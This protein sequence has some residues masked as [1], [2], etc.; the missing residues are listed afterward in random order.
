[1]MSVE[2]YLEHAKKQREFVSG[3]RYSPYHWG[4]S[5]CDEILKNM[6]LALSAGIKQVL[7][8]DARIRLL[9]QCDVSLVS[10]STAP[11]GVFTE[12]GH[13]MGSQIVSSKLNLSAN[14]YNGK[15]IADIL[16]PFATREALKEYIAA[17]LASYMDHE[18]FFGVFLVDEPKTEMYEQ[19]GL[20]KQIIQYV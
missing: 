15:A 10:S 6:D 2:S 5:T 8:Y 19:V 9:T 18:A 13:F 20:V 11:I 14:T 7:I 3:H 1:M 4:N 17:C 16:Y 12:E